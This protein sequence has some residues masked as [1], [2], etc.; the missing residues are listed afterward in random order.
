[1]S[2]TRLTVSERLAPAYIV[3][4]RS[5]LFLRWNR[6]WTGLL[7]ITTVVLADSAG[8]EGSGGFL[9]STTAF[10]LLLE[11]LWFSD[12]FSGIFSSEEAFLISLVPGTSNVEPRFSTPWCGCGCGVT[13]VLTAFDREPTDVTVKV[14]AVELLVMFGFPTFAMTFEPPLLAAVSVPVTVLDLR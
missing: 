14:T 3:F 8:V 11:A 4:G 10:V 5:S 2:R 7:C 6:V 1:M 9:L 12:T 13:A